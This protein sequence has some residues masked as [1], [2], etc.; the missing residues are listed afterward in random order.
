MIGTRNDP[1]WSEFKLLWDEFR[2]AGLRLLLAG[3]YGLFLKQ[4]WVSSNPEIQTVIALP[5]WLDAAPRV[6]KDLDLVVGLDIISSGD[7]QEAIVTILTKHGFIVSEK[8]PR[9]QFVKQLGP[10]HSL[11]V[12]LHAPLPTSAHP[13]VHADDVRV[14]RKPSLGVAG[15]HGRTNPEAVGCDHH[16]FSFE[17]D[18][19]T[20]TVPNAV[21]WAIMKISAM[22]DRWNKSRDDNQGEERRAF[23][24]EQ[25]RK[26]AQDLCRLI[27]MVTR[28]E[29]DH[30][31]EVVKAIRVTPEF[32]GAAAI[33]AESFQIDQG[34]G[35]ILVA[36]KWQ[37][38][39]LVLIRG[40][41]VSWFGGGA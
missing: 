6:T 22:R 18:G 30:A 15:I 38:E 40:I 35:N 31:A 2:A 33:F 37:P 4:N 32:N 36:D 1:M 3:G 14:K 7:A 34:W 13:N 9:W 29:R 23:S 25:A 27:A 26:H 10:G 20:I 41:L 5:R 24:R 8:N 19:L 28:D 12:E 21:T 39:D 11:V 17:T 16:P